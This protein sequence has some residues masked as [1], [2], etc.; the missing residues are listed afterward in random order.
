MGLIG[1]IAVLPWFGGAAYPMHL[2]AFQSQVTFVLSGLR[3]LAGLLGGSFWFNYQGY[4]HMLH[5]LRLWALPLRWASFCFT[6]G[7]F[8]VIGSSIAHELSF[9]REYNLWLIPHSANVSPV[10]FLQKT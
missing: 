10:L 4:D 2:V 5:W 3:A 6:F 9:I 7:V 1:G 8:F